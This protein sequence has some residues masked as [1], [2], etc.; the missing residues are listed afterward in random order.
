MA[1]TC[2]RL[3]PPSVRNSTALSSEPVSLKFGRI[4]GKILEMSLPN[5]SDSSVDSR[6][7]IQLTFPRT[8]LIS[9]LWQM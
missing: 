1:I 9:P 5:K 8:V 3:R 7:F 4:T 2:G 6:A